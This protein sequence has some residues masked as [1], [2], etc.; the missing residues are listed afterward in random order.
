MGRVI[1]CTLQV[2]IAQE[3]TKFGF[4]MSQLAQL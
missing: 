1:D 4:D 2:H 3:D